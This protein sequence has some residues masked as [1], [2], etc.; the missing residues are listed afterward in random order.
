MS[1]SR[2]GFRTRNGSIS[3]FIESNTIQ[4][5]LDLYPNAAAAYSLRKLRNA[6]S[7]SAIRVRRSSDNAEQ[8]IGFINNQLN[9]SSLNSFVGASNGFVT[10]WYDQSGNNKNITQSTASNQP[11]IVT[12]G[13]IIR[14]NSKP[15]IDFSKSSVPTELTNASLTSNNQYWTIFGVVKYYTA[16]NSSIYYYGRWI[17]IG[18][19]GTYDYN[20]TSSFLGFVTDRT[21][22][23]IT[24]PASVTG[25]NNTF[26]GLPIAYNNQYI[27]NSLKT[28]NT[29]KN[30]VNNVLTS[31]FTQS[32]TLNASAIRLGAN[33]TFSPENNS[34]LYGTIQEVI[35]YKTD[36]SS[37]LSAINTN[38]NNYYSAY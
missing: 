32:G 14:A 29:I 2:F 13:V 20:N 26:T 38:I 28:G 11:I 30:G 4:Y 22:F 7:G 31:G 3:S 36:I 5:L 17:S 1:N 19:I 23:G 12:N 16:I 9:I 34:N 27:L 25:Y 35:Y 18:N 10:T 8:D 24:P 33:I 37:N 6:Y 21:D 15:C